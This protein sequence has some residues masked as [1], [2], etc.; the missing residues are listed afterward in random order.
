MRNICL[1]CSGWGITSEVMERIRLL[2]MT[3]TALALL[4]GT[5][6][7][8][9]YSYKCPKCGLIQQYDHPGSYKCPQD[10]WFLTQTR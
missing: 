4:M 1:E 9:V 7:A 2:V 3:G 5:A 8:V 6:L 10:G